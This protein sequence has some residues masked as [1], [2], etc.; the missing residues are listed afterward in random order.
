MPQ[1]INY[2]TQDSAALAQNFPYVLQFGH[3]YATPNNNR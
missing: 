3:L 2:A 1:P